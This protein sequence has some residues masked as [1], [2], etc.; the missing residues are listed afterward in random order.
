MKVN[1]L[2]F[3]NI[4]SDF[5]FSLKEAKRIYLEGGVF[6]YPTDTI[7]GFGANPFNEEAVER[8]DKIKGREAG[9]MYILLIK[10]INNLQKY[11][12]MQSEKHFDFLL[13][14][15]PNPVSVVLNLNE[16]T[17]KIL[18]TDTI[19]FRIPNHRFCL[20]LLGELQMPLISTSV[21]RS[22]ENPAIDPILIKENFE[23]EVD[24]IFYSEKRIFIPASTLIDLSGS[25]PELIR[26][27]KIK[28]KDLLGKFT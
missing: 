7:Y 21:N 20:K 3:I 18:K 19:A 8:I 12:E 9:K 13:S 25:K 15:W 28:F 5:E 22:S 2:P 24:A 26:E 27:G 10:D 23:N 16:K 17:K 11:V 4:E 1:Q 14:I 6:V